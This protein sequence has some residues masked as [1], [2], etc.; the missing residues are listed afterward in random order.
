MAVM[1]SDEKP[2]LDVT[3]WRRRS[4]PERLRRENGGLIDRAC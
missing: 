2:A 4:V 3:P 1:I